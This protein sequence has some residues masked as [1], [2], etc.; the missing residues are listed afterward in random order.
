[1]VSASSFLSSAVAVLGVLGSAT[2][3]H[4]ELE[5]VECAIQFFATGM[6]GKGVKVSTTRTD[7][8]AITHLSDHHRTT[9]TEAPFDKE[10]AIVHF[11]G[12]IDEMNSKKVDVTLK[13]D[14]TANYDGCSFEDLTFGHI[15]DNGGSANGSGNCYTIQ[16]FC[17]H[18]A[19][20]SVYG[21]VYVDA[22]CSMPHAS[23]PIRMKYTQ[24]ETDVD[25]VKDC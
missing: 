19:D 2:A 13:V 16:Q 14:F 10:K 17:G 22:Y 20:A 24:H 11:E 18:H 23:D 1:M 6:H 25:E 15:F 12:A 3:Q 8:Y 7:D 5:L 21:T 4:V 9:V